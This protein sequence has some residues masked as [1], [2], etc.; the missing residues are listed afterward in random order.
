MFNLMKAKQL[1][2][3]SKKVV[4]EIGMKFSNIIN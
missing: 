1:L 3:S 2:T 4:P